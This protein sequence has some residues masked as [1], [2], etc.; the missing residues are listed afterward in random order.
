M[1]TAI[2]NAIFANVMGASP[3][4]TVMYRHVLSC[5]FSLPFGPLIPVILYRKLS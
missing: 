4:F 1:G 2:F 3:V 5:H